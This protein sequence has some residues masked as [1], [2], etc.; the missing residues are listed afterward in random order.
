MV[1]EYEY[2]YVRTLHGLGVWV[3]V[4]Y[5]EMGVRNQERRRY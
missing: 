4:L 2:T 1:W 5:E 3:W